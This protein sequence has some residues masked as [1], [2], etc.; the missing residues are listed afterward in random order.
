VEEVAVED[1]LN[2]KDS[3]L[4]E[5]MIFSSHRFMFKRVETSQEC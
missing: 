2:F 1:I 4:E 5:V 3:F